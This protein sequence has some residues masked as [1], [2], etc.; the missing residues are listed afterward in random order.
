MTATGRLWRAWCQLP[1][2]KPTWPGYVGIDVDDP[3]AT[4]ARGSKRAISG[5]LNWA[6]ADI[7]RGRSGEIIP[8]RSIAESSGQEIDHHPGLRSEVAV[9]RIERED[10]EFGRLGTPAVTTIRRP[11]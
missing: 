11:A 1:R 7:Q 8:P 9:R 10:A 5:P 6:H 4:L 3:K 2:A